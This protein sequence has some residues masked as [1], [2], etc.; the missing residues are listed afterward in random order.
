MLGPELEETLVKY[1]LEMKA[2][3]YGLTRI[4]IKRKTYTLLVQNGI[5][6][7]FGE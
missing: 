3:F 6:H 7:T 5:K 1:I 2:K 4:D